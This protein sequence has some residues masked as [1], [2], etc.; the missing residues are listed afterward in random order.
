ME[1]LEK[2][3]KKKVRVCV[4]ATATLFIDGCRRNMSMEGCAKLK[5]KVA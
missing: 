3:K 1:R 4:V 2:E 5:I